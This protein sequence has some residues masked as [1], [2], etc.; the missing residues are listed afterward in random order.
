M[1]NP[2]VYLLL[3]PEIAFLIWMCGTNIYFTLKRRKH[4]AVDK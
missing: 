1:D 2:L 3:I 4:V